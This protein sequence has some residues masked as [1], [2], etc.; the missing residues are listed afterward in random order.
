M[1]MNEHMVMEHNQSKQSDSAIV[2]KG[3]ID[4]KAIDENSD[5]MV[6]Q[7]QMDF[8]V[9]SDKPGKCP[10][11]GM[12]LKEVT[13]EK[14]AE[15]AV[16]HGFKIKNM[17]EESSIIREGIIDLNQIDENKDGK[18]YEDMMDYNVI[19][20][21]PGTCPLCGMTLKEVSL[22]KAKSN[23]SKNGFPVK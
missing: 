3:E 2:R 5:G 7:D 17:T 8:N 23:L 14:A 11:C 19:S 16:K 18:V 6:F 12:N 1:K 22:E 15:D 9:I 21:K 10:L 20:D 4:I 13:L